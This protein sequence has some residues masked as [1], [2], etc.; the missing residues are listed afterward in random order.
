MFRAE[1]A[2]R[3]GLT[4]RE[5]ITYQAKGALLFAAGASGLVI[6]SRVLAAGEPDIAIARGGPGPA[7]RAAVGLLGG[8]GAFVKPGSKVVVKPN[9]SFA[10]G[11][12]SATNTDPEVVRELVAMCREAGASRVRVLDH[13]LRPN[14]ECIEGVREAC[15]VFGDDLVQ[16]L[17]DE[18]FYR[19]ITLPQ[20]EKFRKTEVMKEVL[21]ADVLIAAP[22]AKAHSST[23][24]SLSLKGMMGLIQN[25]TIMHWR[26]DLSSAIV[27][28][29]TFLRPGLV[30]IDGTRVLTTN[31]PGG[32]GKVLKMDTI[33][34]SRDMV[35]A[36]AQ[37]IELFEWYGR[38]M[39]P[40]QVK[41][42]GIAHERGLGRM[43]IH[44]LITRKV[45]V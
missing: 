11:P 4:R 16:A 5:F 9:M 17:E 18:D 41:H 19:E 36:D 21:E 32:P 14:E 34:A 40:R 1:D 13:P 24:V 33:I 28:L 15:R 8:M 29:C 45:Q 37:A 20:A 12:E 27:D 10:R 38:K 25:R 39:Q 3:K 26:Y 2:F 6:P 44:N 43:D 7:T 30:V 22:V 31:G 23:G 35:A 42:I